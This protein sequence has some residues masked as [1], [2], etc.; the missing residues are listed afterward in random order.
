[1]I[2]REGCLS[3]STVCGSQA[4]DAAQQ[5][6]RTPDA[7]LSRHGRKI[8]SRLRFVAAIDQQQSKKERE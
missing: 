1:M 2:K 7:N 3:T 4:L 6:F 5:I 8:V